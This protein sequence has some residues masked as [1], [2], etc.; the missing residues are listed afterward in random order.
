[1]KQSQASVRITCSV[2][3][4]TNERTVSIDVLDPETFKTI[5]CIDMSPKDFAETLTSHIDR[6]AKITK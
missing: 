5:I 1:M 3:L 2:N 6:P 4:K